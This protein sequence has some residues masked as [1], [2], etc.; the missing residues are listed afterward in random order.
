MSNSE[1][2][3]SISIFL[4]SVIGYMSLLKLGGGGPTYGPGENLIISTDCNCMMSR[5]VFFIENEFV[6]NLKS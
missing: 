3:Q 5:K 1:V 2:G 6:E 4:Y